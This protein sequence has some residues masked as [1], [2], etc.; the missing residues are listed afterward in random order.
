MLL[1]RSPQKPSQPVMPPLPS[2][3][4]SKTSQKCRT[5]IYAKHSSPQR[6]NVITATNIIKKPNIAKKM[7]ISLLSN[8]ITIDHFKPAHTQTNSPKVMLYKPEQRSLIQNKSPS[9]LM[10]KTHQHP[11]CSTGDSVDSIVGP[12]NATKSH[13]NKASSVFSST[14][15]LNVNG[16]VKTKVAPVKR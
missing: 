16:K 10:N 3:S 9:S 13:V 14:L 4:P 2:S 7:S 11:P 5:I 12:I 8:T 1:G 15:R 6:K